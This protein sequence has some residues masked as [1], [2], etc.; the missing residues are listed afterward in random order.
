VLAWV[1]IHKMNE[2][3]GVSHDTRSPVLDLGRGTGPA[4]GGTGT[5]TDGQPTKAL[6]IGGVIVGHTASFIPAGPNVGVDKSTFNGRCSVPS[7]WVIGFAGKGNF[8]H[9]G[10]MTFVGSQCT[11]FN[12]ATGKGTY[13]DGD[14]TFVAANGDVLKSTH[15]GSFEIINNVTHITGGTTV[16]TGGTGR[17]TGASG[18]MAESGTQDLATDVLDVTY[19]GS[20]TYDA[21]MRARS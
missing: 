13:T 21:S 17:F 12:P 18:T 5:G 2:E 11:Q 16:I 15:L 20:I 19:S 6:P 7:T 14:F 9:L 4:D 10:Q 8:S 1:D 3:G